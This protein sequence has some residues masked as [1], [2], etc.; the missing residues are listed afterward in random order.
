MTPSARV[1]AVIDI[2]DRVLAG[3]PAEAVLT[4]W[5]RGNRYAGSGDRAAIRDLV[6]D[7]LRCRASCAARGG[8]NTGRGLVI[9]HFRA[10]DVD[11]STLFNLDRFA[12]APL[13]AEEE[14][15]GSDPVGYDLLDVPHW[16]A[17]HLEASLGADFAD[18]M[19]AQRRRAPVFLRANLRKTTPA[20]AIRALSRDGISAR[21]HPLATTALE[22]T[23]NARKIQTSEAYQTG[24]VEL[25]DASSQAAIEAL[26][27][28]TGMRVLDYC[29]GGGGKVLAM[30]AQADGAFFAHDIDAGRMRDLPRRAERAGAAISVLPPGQV[31]GMFDLV[32]VDAPCSGSGTWRRT[33]DAKWRLGPEMLDSLIRTQRAIL[34]QA[35]GHVTPGGVLAYM[36]CSLL[37]AENIAQVEEF[38]KQP[39]WT[40]LG[41][42]RLTPQTD[43][44]GF[45]V[46]WLRRA[47]HQD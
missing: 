3:A 29:A 27:L 5:A 12:P 41:Q 23:E 26:P 16:I 38:L 33:P 34:Q 20:E 15:A 30:A 18:I 6:Y 31:N 43:G 42:K 45:F 39:G 35:A 46:A 32:L 2:L 40:L 17:P 9:G 11:L 7:V 22:V 36:T 13:D 37:D 1:S 25:Q 21:P 24:L 10:Q 44:D 47:A 4:T 19:D 8:A 28:H 14:G